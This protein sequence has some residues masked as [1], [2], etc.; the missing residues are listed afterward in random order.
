MLRVITV[1]GLILFATILTEAITQIITKSELFKPIRK[2]FFKKKENRFCNWIHELL[3][4]GYCLSFWVT[5]LVLSV[6][7]LAATEYLILLDFS[8]FNMLLNF[9][10]SLFIVHRLSGF[11]HGARDKYFDKSL[12]KRYINILDYS[13]EGD[14][15]NDSAK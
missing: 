8:N 15:D 6:Y 2:F 13:L 3:D 4:C 1:I 14:T 5:L 7:N 10:T 11:I 9:I 12:D